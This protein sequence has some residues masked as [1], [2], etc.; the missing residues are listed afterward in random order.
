[1]TERNGV[2]IVCDFNDDD[3]DDD[4]EDDDDDDDGKHKI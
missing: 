2:R 1:M 3:D 4:A